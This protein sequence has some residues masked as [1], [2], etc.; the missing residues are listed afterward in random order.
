MTWLPLSYLFSLPWRCGYTSLFWVPQRLHMKPNR[1]CRIFSTSRRSIIAR[2]WP[3]R[4][5]ESYFKLAATSKIINWEQWQAMAREVPWQ[6]GGMNENAPLRSCWNI[7]SP[8]GG[9]SWKGL[10]DMALLG[11]SVTRWRLWGFQS[12]WHSLGS[13][14][15]SYLQSKMSALNC[16]I[17]N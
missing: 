10:G 5:G 15:A 9:T 12:P 6:T 7:W 16:S 17:M 13:L 4:K 11:R 2:T 3:L 8:A 1:S 14:S